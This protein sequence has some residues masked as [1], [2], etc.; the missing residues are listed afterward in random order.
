M[1]RKKKKRRA[2][3]SCKGTRKIDYQKAPNEWYVIIFSSDPADADFFIAPKDRDG[4]TE[5]QKRDLEK[6]EELGID[7]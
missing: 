5:K 4:L 7:T 3:I 6:A 2:Y 1:T